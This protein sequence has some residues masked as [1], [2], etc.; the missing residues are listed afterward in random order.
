MQTPRDGQDPF[1]FNDISSQEIPES[2][3][4][5]HFPPGRSPSPW[6]KNQPELG[7]PAGQ[8]GVREKKSH[9]TID[10]A[11]NS[12]TSFAGLDCHER[13]NLLPQKPILGSSGSSPPSPRPRNNPAGHTGAAWWDMEAG[14]TPGR[15]LCDMRTS[16]ISPVSILL[17]PHG[18]TPGPCHT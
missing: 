5:L 14:H 17:G 13:P 12:L 10:P 15:G 6:D 1:F 3:A 4:G 16:P 18:P 9:Y 8:V 2:P 7:T 11:V